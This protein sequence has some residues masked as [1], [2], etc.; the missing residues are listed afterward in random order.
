LGEIFIENINI[1]ELLLKEGLA[2]KY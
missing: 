2:S 1:N